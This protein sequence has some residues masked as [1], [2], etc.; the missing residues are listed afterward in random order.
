[1]DEPNQ[2][3]LG[4]FECVRK[5]PESIKLSYSEFT[6]TA[7]FPWSR[8][9]TLVP[10]TRHLELSRDIFGCYKCGKGVLAIT[11]TYVI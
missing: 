10:R 3:R 4:Y 5:G 1:M 11:M 7:I 6:Q 8:S 2:F 9:L